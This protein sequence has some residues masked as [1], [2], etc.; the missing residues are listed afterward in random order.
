MH[1]RHHLVQ[2]G[3]TFDQLLATQFML[4]RP[5]WDHEAALSRNAAR[6]DV[7][8]WLIVQE[9]TNARCVNGL[10]TRRGVVHLQQ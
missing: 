4:F 5:G 6:H 8:W 2:I 3:I 9:D 10:T 7:L 1:M